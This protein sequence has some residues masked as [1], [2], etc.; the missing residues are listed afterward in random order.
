[1]AYAEFDDLESLVAHH[2]YEAAL[3]W[4]D[5]HMD[6]YPK[7]YYY[8]VVTRL[9]CLEG[10]ERYQEI[11][12]IL[13]EELNLPYIPQP[14]HDQLKDLDHQ[15]KLH[16][17][18]RT[19]TSSEELRLLSNDDFAQQLPHLLLSPQLDST[20][21]EM[22]ERSINALLP[23]I[24][25]ILLDSSYP[26]PIKSLVLD[27]LVRQGVQE[28]IS[29]SV[30]HLHLSVIPSQ[31]D[32]L[33]QLPLMEDVLAPLIAVLNQPNATYFFE[34]LFSGYILNH[35]PLLPEEDE[36][37]AIRYALHAVLKTQ[38]HLIPLPSEG[39]VLSPHE[40]ALRDT[41]TN[42]FRKIIQSF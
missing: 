10:L 34:Q 14:Y 37:D 30:D 28:E 13:D 27:A 7:R 25:R 39:E 31:L 12:P 24:Q 33:D 26:Q 6:E 1:M 9:I 15:V 11:V 32:A 2:Q 18:P 22:T 38:L 20:L 29:Y 23:S 16:L 21:K 36:W 4:L 35:Y 17:K 5:E 3:A 19:L 42:E 40:R 41:Y 8:L